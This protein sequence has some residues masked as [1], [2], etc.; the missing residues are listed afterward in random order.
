M[1]EEKTGVGCFIAGTPLLTGNGSKRI[2]EIKVGDY[3]VSRDES[4]LKKLI[5]NCKKVAIYR[6]SSLVRYISINGKR[7]GLS[8][9]HPFWV[10]DKG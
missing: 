6:R 3:V 7:I 4:D 2:E 5:I 10:V 8:E 1:C 9:E